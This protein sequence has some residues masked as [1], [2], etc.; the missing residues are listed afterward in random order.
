MG[1]QNASSLA[2][3]RPVAEKDLLLLAHAGFMYPDEGVRSLPTI[4]PGAPSLSSDKGQSITV[5]FFEG[6]PMPGGERTHVGSDGRSN[7]KPI[8]KSKWPTIAAYVKVRPPH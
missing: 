8:E 5:H 1:F 3:G 7:F 4:E 6:G 2:V